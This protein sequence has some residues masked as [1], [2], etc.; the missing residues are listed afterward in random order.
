M[1]NI[2]TFEQTLIKLNLLYQVQGDVNLMFYHIFSLLY[3]FF[4]LQLVFSNDTKA[5]LYKVLTYTRIN[6]VCI[7]I[8]MYALLI[9]Y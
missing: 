4:N 3:I 2:K 6:S 5:N 9:I 7:H 8:C 1:Y